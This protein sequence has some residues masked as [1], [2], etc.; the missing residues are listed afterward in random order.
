MP[1]VDVPDAQPPRPRDR[2]RCSV[3]SEAAA[4]PLAGSAPTD[5]RW[6]LVEVP[7]PWGRKAVTGSGLPEAVVASLASYDGRVQLVRRPGADDRTG[8]GPLVVVADPGEAGFVVR[9][10]RLGSLDDLA[11]LPDLAEADL[12]PHDEPLWLVCTNGRRDLCCAERGRPVALALAGVRPAQV[13]ETSHL[14]G[15]RY[16]ATVLHLPSGLLLGRLDPTTAATALAEVEAGRVPRGLVRGRVGS[17]PAAQV[18]ELAVREREAVWGLDGVRPA[19]PPVRAAADPDLAEVTV[20]TPAGTTRV[21]VRRAPG[22]P[23]RASCADDHDKPST[24]YEVVSL[25]AAPGADG[26]D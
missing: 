14:G 25:S 2:P 13:W 5:E 15:H 6:L 1:D 21:E 20:R 18:A 26:T 9:S 11:D 24:R 7:G 22:P 12:R 3:L 23:G 4:E 8:Q 19:G 16:A 17:A 10:A